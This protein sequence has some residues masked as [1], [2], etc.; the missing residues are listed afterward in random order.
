MN[1]KELYDKIEAYLRE[2]LS[3]A[4]KKAFEAEIAN[5]PQLAEQVEMHRFEWDGMEVILE[6]D[7]RA[8]MAQWQEEGKKGE[9]IPPS[10]K[11][12]KNRLIPIEKGKTTVRRLYYGL[13]IAASITLLLG[14]LLWVFTKPNPISDVVKN[15]ASKDTIARL[16]L[17][18]HIPKSDKENTPIVQMDKKPFETPA[19]PPRQ[20]NPTPIVPNN[21]INR[22]DE[23][24]LIAF[25]EDAY[26]EDVPDYESINTSRG[27]NNASVL[28]EAG[29]A[30][31]SKDF[32]KVISLL[33]N[34]LALDENFNALELLAHAYFQQKQ[35]KLALPLFKDLLRLSGKRTHDKSEWYLL[36]CYLTDY[37]HYKSEFNVLSQKISANTEHDYTAQTKT[38]LSK[39]QRR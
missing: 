18:T 24:T 22:V 9:I 23:T 5:N 36:L 8:K 14:A 7:L 32:T 17:P 31:D 16:P 38:L 3:A 1:K 21:E 28:D 10:V 6:N 11:E 4:D 13:A 20:E 33:K 15:D 2:E 37:S 26:K 12:V 19:I 29:K 27:G 35:Y 30:Y 34:T 39:I 25:A